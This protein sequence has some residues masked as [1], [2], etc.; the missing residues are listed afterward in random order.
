VIVERAR[1]A[2]LAGAT[3][4]RGRLGYGRSARL[5]AHHAFDAEGDLPLV[6][7]I[8][9]HTER[10]RAFAGGL[11]DFEGIGLVTLEAVEILAGLPDATGAGIAR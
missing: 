9:D 2:R 3:V 10:L 7:E 8:V 11:A 1:T 5:H 4:L 6:V